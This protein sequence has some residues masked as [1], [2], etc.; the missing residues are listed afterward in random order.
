MRSRQYF[1]KL[2]LPELPVEG[3]L[4]EVGS[5]QLRVAI[6]DGDLDTMSRLLRHCS[7][8]SANKSSHELPVAELSILGA[9]VKQHALDCLSQPHISENLHKLLMFLQ[10]LHPMLSKMTNSEIIRELLRYT[11]KHSN[12]LA[13]EDWCHVAS[14]L[15]DWNSNILQ[16]NDVKKYR[17]AYWTFR[18]RFIYR[19]MSNVKNL[20]DFVNVCYLATGLSEFLQSDSTKVGQKIALT[21]GFLMKNPYNVQRLSSDMETYA[22]IS[23]T[24]F[25]HQTKCSSRTALSLGLETISRMMAKAE[26]AGEIS[27]PL[28]MCIKS[29]SNSLAQKE[30]FAKYDYMRSKMFSSLEA[31][32]PI[33]NK[34]GFSWSVRLVHGMIGNR[35]VHMD[36]VHQL[37]MNALEN[38]S[39]RTVTRCKE[40]SEMAVYQLFRWLRR[41]CT[42]FMGKTPLRV[43]APN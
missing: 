15:N 9:K 34:L 32:L 12:S 42:L 38:E 5:D 41:L 22:I 33:S 14:F 13:L 18:N 26:E 6:K 39:W 8:Q 11:E 7:P 3:K 29:V 40:V 19:T 24:L 23:R 25:I 4:S 10:P 27:T 2:I 35:H 21:L 31:A 37:V 1:G 17:P 30:L 20:E 36:L 28:G 16:M 43:C